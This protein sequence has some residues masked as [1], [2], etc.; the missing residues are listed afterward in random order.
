M[1]SEYQY[2]NIDIIISIITFYADDTN[3]SANYSFSYNFLRRR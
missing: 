1:E 2:M 3:I